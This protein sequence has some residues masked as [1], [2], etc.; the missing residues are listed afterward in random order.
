MGAVASP[1][2][3]CPHGHGGVYRTP[4]RR[5][6]RLHVAD[7]DRDGGIIN[8]VPRTSTGRLKTEDSAQPVCAPAALHP[9]LE[10]WLTHRLDAPA[11][12]VMPAEVPW[13]FPG[14][15]RI[16]PW[17]TGARDTSHS[18]DC[19]PSPGGP[20]STPSPGRA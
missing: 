9:I 2:S 19:K 4:R 15:T 5:A 7:L 17:T 8:L 3:L 1:P 20:A 10:A 14:S 16:G 18:T 12:F 13:L 11:G 6:Q